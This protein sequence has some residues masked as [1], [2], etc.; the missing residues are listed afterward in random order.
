MSI[1]ASSAPALADEVRRFGVFAL[2]GVL[3]TAFGFG[4]FAALLWLGLHYSLALLLATCLGVGF[5]FMTTGRIVFGSARWSRLS[6]FVGVYA[7]LYGTNLLA[8][9]AMQQLG[10]GPLLGQALLVPPMAAAAYVMNRRF[11]FQP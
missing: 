3:N 8:L 5:N 11:V 2:V 9:W 1:Q 4:V 7:V 6:R 10:T